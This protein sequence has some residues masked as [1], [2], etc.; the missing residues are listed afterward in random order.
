MIKF[1]KCKKIVSMDEKITHKLQLSKERRFLYGISVFFAHSGDSWFWFAGLL[2]LW[3]LSENFRATA[4]FFMIAISIQAILVLSLKFLIK[5][6]RPEGDWGSI[7]RNTDPHSF[8]SG[9]A[10]RAVMLAILAW[11][12]GNIPLAIILSIWAPLVGIARVMLGVHYC[13]DII[14]GW[15]IGLLLGF[16]M[17]ALQPIFIRMFPFLL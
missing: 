1:M 6:S 9:H 15:I 5:R 11:G 7:Y 8:P 2:L 13:I 10:V 12:I 14:A 16:S 4:A 3:F 17:L